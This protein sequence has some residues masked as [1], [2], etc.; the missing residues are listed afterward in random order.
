M[1][2]YHSRNMQLEA[3][4]Q[5]EK[6]QDTYNNTNRFW[7]PRWSIGMCDVMTSWINM[8]FY[9]ILLVLKSRLAAELRIL[10]SHFE[11]Q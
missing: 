4:A 9:V 5:L 3:H 2:M 10:N 7:V 8:L 11:H 1:L 6:S